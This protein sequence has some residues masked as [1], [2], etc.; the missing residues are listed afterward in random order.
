M[1]NSFLLLLLGC[2]FITGWAQAQSTNTIN[3]DV[4]PPNAAATTDPT[5]DVPPQTQPRSSQDP[6]DDPLIKQVQSRHEKAVQGDEKETKALTADLEK[7]TKEQPTNH[8]LQAYLGS[9]YTLDSRDAWPGPSKYTFLKNGIQTLD[10]AVLADPANPAVRFVR[11][12][13]FYN[14]PTI[15]GRRKTAR[16]DFQTLL[17]QIEGQLPIACRLNLQTQQAIYYYAGLSLAQLSEKAQAQDAWE[18]G[19]KLD[20]TS[21]L[22]DKIHLELTKLKS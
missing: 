15:F 12:M 21:D 1:K 11:A 13:N 18:R 7:W 22:A 8:L 5:A 16:D 3:D 10:A 19:W 9:T 4:P 6:F 2:L 20:P 17:K 14:L